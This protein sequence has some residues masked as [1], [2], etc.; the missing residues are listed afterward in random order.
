MAPEALQKALGTADQRREETR[1]VLR[2][3]ALHAPQ[4][5]ELRNGAKAPSWTQR[6]E[7]HHSDN[8]LRELIHHQRDR[9]DTLAGAITETRT[10]RRELRLDLRRAPTDSALATALTASINRID[11]RLERLNQ[12]RRSQE[13]QLAT[14]RA[15]S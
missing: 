10:H 14:L 15:E 11:A 9:L 3:A 4:P 2:E 12:D 7:G 5:A 6:A 1:Q 13:Q 8:E